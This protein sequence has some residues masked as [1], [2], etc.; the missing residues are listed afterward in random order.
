MVS[1]YCFEVV[2]TYILPIT[3]IVT[4][5]TFTT[6]FTCRLPFANT[7]AKPVLLSKSKWKGGMMSICMTGWK[8]I[9]VSFDWVYTGQDNGHASSS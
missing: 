4:T 3:Q 6:L 9:A 2:G 7:Q 1:R 8:L 5:A